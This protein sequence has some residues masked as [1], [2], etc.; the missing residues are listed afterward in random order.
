[1]VEFSAVAVSKQRGERIGRERGGGEGA[2]TA[3][4]RAEGGAATPAWARRRWAAH[5]ATLHGEETM[6]GKGT[7]RWVG[8]I[9]PQFESIQTGQVIQTVSE[10]KF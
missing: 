10:F 6:E 2:G 7:K 4:S 5:V 1:V 8:T 9:V 3:R